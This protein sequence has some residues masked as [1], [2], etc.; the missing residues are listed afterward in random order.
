M[1]WLKLSGRCRY[2]CKKRHLDHVHAAFSQRGLPIQLDGLHYN[3][4]LCS[5]ATPDISALY[6][7]TLL[8]ESLALLTYCILWETYENGQLVSC[9]VRLENEEGEGGW[10]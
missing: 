1:E 8:F 10:K 4:Q 3:V 9:S 7:Q 6:L 2:R 5:D